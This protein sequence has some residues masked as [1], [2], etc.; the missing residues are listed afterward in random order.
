MFNFA[1]KIYLTDVLSMTQFIIFDFKMCFAVLLSTIIVGSCYYDNDT[2]DNDD[3][4]QFQ[5]QKPNY[6]KQAT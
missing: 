2:G 1:Y 4:A 3:V 6:V 5:L